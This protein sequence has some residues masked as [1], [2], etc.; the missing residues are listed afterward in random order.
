[1]FSQ[2]IQAREKSER[3]END[4]TKSVLDVTILACNLHNKDQFL[5]DFE[6]SLDPF[7]PLNWSFKKKVLTTFLY[8]LCTFGPQSASSIYGPVRTQISDQFDVSD[9]VST[10]GISLFLIGV[11]FGPMFFAPVSELYGRKVGVLIP[12]FISGIFALGGATADNF[13]TIMIMRF[14]QGMFGGAPI[15][16]T[17]G[18]L[19]DIWAPAVRAH[20]LVC[21]AFVVTGAPPLAPIIGAALRTTGSDAWRWTQYFTA[22]YTFV[23]GSIAFIFIPETY[24]PVLLAQKAK[25]MRFQTGNWAYHAKQDE[26]EFSVKELITK[27]FVRPFALLATPIV[28]AMSTY[29]SFVFGILYLA[30]TAVPVEFNKVRGWDQL[31]ATLPN[32][33]IFIGVVVGGVLNVLL[34]RKYTAMLIKD[35]STIIPEERLV[36]MKVGCFLLPIGMLIFGW[37][38][39][40][41]YPWIA[42]IIGLIFT[43]AGFLTVFQGC[44]NYLVDSFPRYAASAIAATTFLRS[45]MAAAFPLFGTIM[46]DN[47]GVPWGSSII[48]FVGLGMVPIP[49][50]FYRFGSTLRSK[51]PYSKTVM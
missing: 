13:Q 16:N 50:I 20:A 39:H 37:T 22:I 47:V 12:F 21:Y 33:A 25:K 45:C 36:A 28:T 10:L 19:G 4:L 41:Q 32:A 8:A 46:F 7:K 23:V 15:A 48:A 44:I 6:G 9:E 24:H 40:P 18:V 38:S 5:V 43:A 27:H 51:N 17:G 49:Y 2:D 26:I 1:M 42:P 35:P 34:G 29:G 14:F 11:G 30:V 3:E 31:T